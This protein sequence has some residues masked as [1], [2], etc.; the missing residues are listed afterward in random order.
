MAISRRVSER[1]FEDA[2]E[3][4][5]LAGGPDACPEDGA[6]VREIPLPYGPDWV[7]G[8]F[9][10]RMAEEYDR[11]LCLVPRDVIDFIYATQ[12]KE[13]DRLKQYYGPDVKDRFLKRLAR[14]VETHGVL[15][16]LR[17]GIKDAG[18]KFRLAYFRPASRLNVDVQRLYEANAFSVIRQLKYSEGDEQSID[19]VLFLNG[20]PIFTAEL[21][22]PLTWQTVEHAI[23]QYRFDRDPRVPL[24]AYRRCLA[25]FAVDPDLVYVAARLEG[26]KTRFL[27]FNQGKFGGAGNPPVSPVRGGYPTSYLW[28]QVWSRDSVLD[29]IEHFVEEIEEE[30]ED[31][32]PTGRQTLIFPRYHQLDA[33]R[34]LVRH[35]REHGPGQRYLIQHSAGSGKSNSIAWLAHQLSVLHDDQ[36][37][38]VFDSI[39]VITDRIVL[40]RQLQRTV[41]QFEQTAGVVENIDKTSR[42]LKDALESGKTIIVTTLQKF[43]VIADDIKDLPGKRFAVVIDEAH[44]SQTGEST[45]SLKDVLAAKT[46]EEAAAEESD[47][48][49]DVE[50]RIVADM[51]RR[52]RL[53]NVSYFA[54][55]AT[56]KAKTL[57]LFGTQRPDGKFEAFSLYS[58]RQAIDETFILDVLENYTTYKTYWR[59]L[60]T[61]EDD[62]RYDRT[63]ASYL[64]RSFV[65]LHDHAIRKKV[66]IIVEH[67]RER[68]AHRIGGL[69]K[70]MIVTPS[71][72]H[73][74]RYKLALD[75]HLRERAYPYKALV[76]FSGTVSDGGAN[77]TELGMN[78]FPEAQTAGTF[79]R[80]EYRFLVVAEK[81]QMGFDQPLLHT[82]YVDKKLGGVHA[83]QT[84]SRLN[85][86]YPDKAETMIL[87]FA[88]ETDEIQKAFEPYYEKTLLSEGTDPNLLYD[89]ERRLKGF[90]VFD[91]ADLQAFAGIYFRPNARH[92]QFYAAL[93][94]TVERVL[95]RPKEEQF[96]FR[97]VLTDYVR[98]YAF[99]SQILTFADADLEKLYVFARLLRRYLPYDRDQ[100]P[101]EIQQNIDME[102]Y[103]I[104]QT[105]SGRVKLE[106]GQREVE[107]IGT[108]VTHLPPAEE[109]EPLSQI[110]QELNQRFGTEFMEDDK[111]FIRDLEKRLTVDQALVLSVRAN[112]PEN[113]RLTFDH[114]VSDRLQDMV[115]KNFKFY[116]RVTDD[117][118]F[119]KFFLDWLFERFRRSVDSAPPDDGK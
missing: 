59:L 38:R 96:D 102:S 66:E 44:S 36:D 82:M 103:R 48:G 33:V 87:D 97:G 2:I 47:E 106:R 12:P 57:E 23:R 91:D 89:L 42:Q 100:L 114:V 40:D 20:L 28:E 65:G 35:A 105:F 93:A 27:P 95:E 16:V 104:Q 8:G 56:P 50:D 81:F 98:L 39:V 113:A 75:E 116:K 77:L 17:T 30:D 19:L 86:V 55:T 99:L 1:S 29:L 79:K 72:L 110:I 7:P 67:F 109:L 85:R 18:V 51:K 24:L 63:K 34:R 60:K 4:A 13:W 112:T 21:K 107:P 43:P 52:G 118:Q 15:D 58:M 25:H 41:K 80:P 101:V 83:V 9:R 53:P 14:E 49:E 37:R 76:A 90:R 46:L 61:A 69:A 70:A 115:D 3:C 22:N 78:G 26:G 5:L 108:G 92:E 71:R 94:P 73:A 119:A 74:V 10:R 111:V 31:G 62:P 88:N 11:A 68:V 45:K 32:R 64:L 54:F 117:Q 6:V 84:L